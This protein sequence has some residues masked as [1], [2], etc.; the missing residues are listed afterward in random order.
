MGGQHPG[1]QAGLV[2]GGKSGQ[3]LGAGGEQNIAL[4]CG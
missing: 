2:Q 3:F 4:R 1:K